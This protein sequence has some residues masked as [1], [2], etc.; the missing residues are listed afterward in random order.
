MTLPVGS[1]TRTAPESATSTLPLD[2]ILTAKA[3]SSRSTTGQRLGRGEGDLVEDGSL[4]VGALVVAEDA[5]ALGGVVDSALVARQV[6][7]VDARGEFVGERA[8]VGETRAHR[9]E[10]G[11]VRRELLSDV[12]VAVAV[13]GNRDRV[14]RARRRS[15]SASRRGEFAHLARGVPE[16]VVVGDVEV[17]V[18]SNALPTVGTVGVVVR[19]PVGVVAV[20]GEC[21][22]IVARRRVVRCRPASRR[23]RRRS[24]RTRRR[25]RRRPAWRSGRPR[26]R[27]WRRG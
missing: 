17:P 16:G 21:A 14:A 18:E 1:N 3:G 5:R 13:E 12:H 15:R 4:G 6:D 25:C 24:G 7:G 11:D 26:R 8:D 19:V 22:E 23:P 10:L 9:A 27:W 20:V 2:R